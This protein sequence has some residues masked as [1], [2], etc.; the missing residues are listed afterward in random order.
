ML[1][2]L[3]LVMLL[4]FLLLVVRGLRTS[5]HGASRKKCRSPCARSMASTCRAVVAMTMPRGAR[6]PEHKNDP[7][8]G[9]WGCLMADA[10]YPT[11]CGVH[12]EESQ[13]WP[14]VPKS[15]LCIA[16]REELGASLRA[17]ESQWDLALDAL[18]RG[19]GGGG[20]SERMGGSDIHPPLPI[21]ANASDAM[22]LARN[23]V[24]SGAH[25]LVMDR[26]QVRLPDDQ[27]TP[28]L[29]GWLA[30]WHL[31]HLASHPRGSWTVE[32]YTEI[33][34]AAEAITKASAEGTPETPLPMPCRQI[35]LVNGKPTQCPG[36]VTAIPSSDGTPGSVRCSTDA[37]HTVAWDD[38]VKAHR[39]SRA[40][41]LTAM[42]RN[43]RPRRPLRPA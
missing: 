12:A 39:G 34:R 25:Q 21:N 33:Q 2:F 8:C 42:A 9:C 5:E 28:A 26:D 32:W 11:N 6:M 37:G 19:R 4:R 31:E 23:A 13:W 16:C 30:R 27:S 18:A 40:K 17:I 29:A 24:W 22:R 20:D 7:S 38:W 1:V 35:S 3:L 43:A 41:T 15:N 14:A 10:D 36:M